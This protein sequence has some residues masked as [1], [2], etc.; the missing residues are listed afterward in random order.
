MFVHTVLR[1]LLYYYQRTER[2]RGR[3]QGRG[4]GR[5]ATRLAVEA[6]RQPNH[7][8]APADDSGEEDSEPENIGRVQDN[9]NVVENEEFPV[10]EI[11]DGES[12][13]EAESA[14]NA[15]E[16]DIPIYSRINVPEDL[17]ELHELG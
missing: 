10:F 13:I 6:L 9:I 1:Y 4:R 7:V 2:G 11:L 8:L 3:R 14:P 17:Q 5:N 15:V 16:E 12:E